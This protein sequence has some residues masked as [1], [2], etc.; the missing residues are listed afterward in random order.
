LPATTSTDQIQELTAGPKRRSATASGAD[1]ARVIDSAGL[2]ILQNHL[3]GPVTATLLK[4]Q[5]TS[6]RRHSETGNLINSLAQLTDNYLA[7]RLRGD[8][9]DSYQLLTSPLVPTIQR[10]QY[11]TGAEGGSLEI[12]NEFT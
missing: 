11:V 7:T 4:R 6:V 5:P 2:Q 8:A 1:P 12:L 10:N 9:P 3:K